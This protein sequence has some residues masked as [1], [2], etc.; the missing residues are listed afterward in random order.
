MA[1]DDGDVDVIGRPSRRVVLQGGLLFGVVAWGGR[2][3]MSDDTTFVPGGRIGFKK[4]RDAR[5]VNNSWTLLSAD[6]TLRVDVR[7]T[8]RLGAYN[9]ASVWD[10]DE[11]SSRV[12]PELLLPG[13]EVRRFRD[14][15]YGADANY[16]A[17]A[18]VVRDA[19]WMGEVDISIGDH[20]GLIKHPGGQVAR[21][22]PLMANLLASIQVRP[23]LPVAAALAEL[24]VSLDTSGL[25]PRLIGNKLILSLYTPTSAIDSWASNR[26]H[27][28]LDTLSLLPFAPVE[29]QQA[30]NADIFATSRK[31]KGSSVVQG[32]HCI[33]L[34]FP[35]QALE[36]V[37]DL[38]FS[39]ITAFGRRRSQDLVAS[40]NAADRKPIL[41]ALEQAF[42]SLSLS[43]EL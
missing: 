36:G 27:I 41:R 16:A 25:H 15:R 31:I 17:E 23:P 10:K 26:T 28:M 35:E 7:E 12:E 4:P 6:H 42:Q 1:C 38:F 20:G 40:Y 14:L 37:P 8:I 19:T 30:T 39:R 5:V 32:R 21:W 3:A 33:G 9:D 24:G 2:E 29:D 34:A 18:I 43:E 11:R 13:F 22:T